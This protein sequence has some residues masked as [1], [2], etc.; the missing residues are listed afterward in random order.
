MPSASNLLRVSVLLRSTTGMPNND[1]G[2]MDINFGGSPVALCF[3]CILRMC[4]ESPTDVLNF[5]LQYLHLTAERGS[6]VV[7]ALSDHLHLA[8]CSRINTALENFSL[9]RLYMHLICAEVSATM[10]ASG[11]SAERSIVGSTTVFFTLVMLMELLLSSNVSSGFGEPLD[12]PSRRC[13]TT[14]LVGVTMMPRDDRMLATSLGFFV[15]PSL[16]GGA[17]FGFEGGVSLPFTLMVT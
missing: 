17:S 15:V 1:V 8:E 16:D 3:W 11:S 14:R 10:L 7:L 13:S 5:E 4:T 2:S 6:S 12:V 9:H